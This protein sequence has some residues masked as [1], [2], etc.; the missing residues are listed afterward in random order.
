MKNIDYDEIYTFANELKKMDI[1]VIFE[2]IEDGEQP[3]ILFYKTNDCFWTGIYFCP[4]SESIYGEK[5]L[6]TIFT[7]HSGAVDVGLFDVHLKESE[8]WKSLNINE[9]EIYNQIFIKN[10]INLYEIVKAYGVDPT[11]GDKYPDY[12][13]EDDI[14]LKDV[15]MKLY[16][17]QHTAAGRKFI[18]H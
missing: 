7:E 10:A 2:I 4:N 18:Y 5:Y 14:K 9:L 15:Y 1:Q 13:L 3:I 17:K 12:N 11:I 6:G 8:P 16:M